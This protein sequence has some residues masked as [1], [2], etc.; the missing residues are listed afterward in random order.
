[1]EDGFYARPKIYQRWSLTIV[2]KEIC[3]EITLGKVPKKNGFIGKNLSQ[4]LNPPTHPRVYVRKGWNS[5]QKRRFLGWFDQPI[6]GKAFLGPSLN[7]KYIPDN[8]SFIWL[9]LWA[10]TFHWVGF[11]TKYVELYFSFN[12]FV[13]THAHS[14]SSL[15][16]SLLW[17]G[18]FSTHVAK[19]V[20]FI[21][22]CI[23]EI[24]VGNCGCEWNKY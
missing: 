10:D 1:M 3:I 21:L 2:L 7:T 9:L 15:S 12:R 19:H 22:R 8:K 23:R 18:T 16:I 11:L 20:S 17:S 6:F 4:S 14:W 5:G 24:L 13:W